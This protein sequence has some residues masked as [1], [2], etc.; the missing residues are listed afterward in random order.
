METGSIAVTQP[1]L[2]LKIFCYRPVK[3]EF[4]NFMSFKLLIIG[5]IKIPPLFSIVLFKYNFQK[6]KF[7]VLL[8]I[9]CGCFKKFG[10]VFRIQHMFFFSAGFVPR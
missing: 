3:T 9:H 8:K 10:H 1:V 7:P 2:V 4:G 6:K 5:F